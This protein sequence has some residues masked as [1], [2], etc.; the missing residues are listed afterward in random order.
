M[1]TS[2]LLGGMHTKFDFGEDSCRQHSHSRNTF[3]HL[4][5]LIHTYLEDRNKKLTEISVSKIKHFTE[6][7]FF[8]VGRNEASCER[9]LRISTSR[10]TASMMV[11]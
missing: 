8:C 3:S 4:F 2:Q 10:Y 5:H 7:K 11:Q 9:N 6:F 1:M